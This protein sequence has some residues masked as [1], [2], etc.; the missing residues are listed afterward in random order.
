MIN[1]NLS[2][3]KKE[4]NINAWELI[5]ISLDDKDYTS[6]SELRR[7]LMRR[8]LLNT[9]C[10]IHKWTHFLND[11][12]FLDSRMIGKW[13]HYRLNAKGLNMKL[14]KITEFN[15]MESSRKRK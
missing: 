4:Y 13:I 2:V 6:L 7:I 12:G 11:K 14:C 5:I 8:K 15:L 3:L 10:H 9:Y 1:I